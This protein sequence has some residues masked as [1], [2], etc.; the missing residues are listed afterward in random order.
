M[1]IVG[2]NFTKLSGEK[3]GGL[4]GKININNN[5]M[6]TDAKQIKVNVGQSDGAGLLIKFKYVCEYKPKVG[7]LSLEG[8][9]ILMEKEEDVK[10]AVDSWKK[11][12]KVGPELTRQVMSHILNKST[13]QAIILTRDLGLP[14]PI[15]LPKVQD[16][17]KKAAK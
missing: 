3:T 11:D 17:A 15:P 2:F 9:V 5:V 7:N 12:K 4:S 16:E 13:V 6:F 8:D 14:A 1:S 10:A